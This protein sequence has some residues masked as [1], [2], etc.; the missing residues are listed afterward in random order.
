MPGPAPDPNALRRDRKDDVGWT[1]LPKC[2]RLTPAPEWPLLDLTDRE[3]QLWQSL[4]RKPQAVLW[5][6][7]GQF[8]EVA[9][10]VRR[11]AEVEQA[12]SAVTLGALVQKQ[13]A[14]LLLTIPAMYKAHV[15]IAVD[16]VSAAR[17]K[18][19]AVRASASQRLKARNA[20][21]S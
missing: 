13:M 12:E 3:W 21:V 19:A 4:W 8:L 7:T 2:G 11:L 5:E 10:L 1:T 15:N 16:Q 9:L 6:H 17:G 18:P 14:D 20:Q